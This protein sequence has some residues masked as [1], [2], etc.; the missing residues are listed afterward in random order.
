MRQIYQ[1]FECFWLYQTRITNLNEDDGC[2]EG[3]V[4]VV[5]EF[6]S[7]IDGDTTE[8]RSLGIDDDPHAW[9]GVGLEETCEA[10]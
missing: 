1:E 6:Q 9:R 5:G 10:I 7:S 8:R 3:V 4:H 2:V